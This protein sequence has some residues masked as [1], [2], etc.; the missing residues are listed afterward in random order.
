M[1]RVGRTV[2]TAL[3][4]LLAALLLFSIWK[5][6]SILHEYKA[7]ER[8]YN[9][10]SSDVVMTSRPSP[11]PAPAAAVPTA[12]EPQEEIERSPVSVDFASLAERSGDVVGWLCLPD[13]VINYPVVQGSDNAYYL[14]RFLDGTPNSGGTLFV[15]FVCPSD[16]SG[17]STII[18]GH[19]MRDGSMFALIDDYIDQAFFDAHPI[20]YLNTPS[21]NY[22][23]EFFSG[24][25]SDPEGFAY[26]TSFADEAA[27]GAFLDKLIASSSVSS[28]VN[29]SSADRILLLSTCT[30][31]DLDV[32]F[33]LAGKL[34]P[35]G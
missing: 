20:M 26:Q 30:Y 18:Y 6:F 3:C 4:I 16:F 7:A 10:L 25:V 31:T 23:V 9:S 2:L 12:E 21:Q 33:I 29:V 14:N 11:S 32:R 27:F 22:K 28:T 24:F 1:R 19:N 34:V 35:I 15:D 5:V 13:T 17:K 8:R